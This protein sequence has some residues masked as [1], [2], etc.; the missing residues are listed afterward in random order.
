MNIHNPRVNPSNLLVNA[1]THSYFRSNNYLKFSERIGL[2]CKTIFQGFLNLFFNYLEKE[3]LQSQ[4][5]EIFW[6]QKEITIPKFIASRLASSDISLTSSSQ[7]LCDA[8]PFST[9]TRT[10]ETMDELE[11]ENK[12]LLSPLTN[13]EELNAL[14]STSPK[15]IESST[16]PSGFF[17]S[18]QE[19][20]RTLTQETIDKLEDENKL[21]L[22]LLTNPEELNALKGTSP[23]K[24]E[25]SPQPS[26]FFSSPQEHRRTLTQE[27]ID[28]LE[29]ENKLLLNLLTNLEALNALE[30][31]FPKKIESSPQP[32][33]C[34]SS[35]RKLRRARTQETID[36]LE[37]ENKLLLNSLANPEA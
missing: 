10:Q 4:W 31:P 21:L 20:R 37:D 25:S 30:D 8:P 5:R 23:K 32:S 35:P 11:D 13:P 36:N 29:D 15:E 9:R 27:T 6:G 3:Q 24:I 26:G 16:Q 12:P 2:L 7:T 1:D 17:S 14:K 33:V 28:K 18:P 19:H 22:N 34:F